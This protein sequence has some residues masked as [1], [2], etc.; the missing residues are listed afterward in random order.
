MEH[1]SRRNISA[2]SAS[3]MKNRENK[4]LDKKSTATQKKIILNYVKVVNFVRGKK[5]HVCEN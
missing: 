1:T 4:E 3:I 2:E 5:G